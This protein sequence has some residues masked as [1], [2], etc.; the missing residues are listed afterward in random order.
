MKMQVPGPD[1]QACWKTAQ[2]DLQ[3]DGVLRWTSNEAWP[4]DAGAIDIKKALGVWLL[5]PPGWRRLD[6]ILPEHRWTL[7][8]DDDEVLQ[9][10]I[11][12][13]EDVAPEKPVSEIRNGWMEKKGAVGGGWKV[14]FFVLL[15]THELLYFESDRSPKCKGVID[16]KEATSCARVQTPDY[17]YEFAFEVVSPKRTWI[18]CPDDEHSMKEWMSDIQP[19]LGK[20]GQ[21]K[22]GAGGRKKRTSVSQ[23]GNRTYNTDGANGD[24]GGEG[25]SSEASSPSLKMGWLQKKGEVNT[26]W[27]NRYFVLKPENAYRDIPMT[28]WYYKDQ[29]TARIGK[30]GSTIEV[31][32]TS[33]TKIQRES[34]QEAGKPFAFAVVTPT[35]KYCLCASDED[36]LT[37]WIKLL[38]APPQEDDDLDKER[39]ESMMSMASFTASGPLVEVHSGWMKKKGQGM[40]GGKMQ[41]RYFVL[42]DNKELH[43]FEGQSMEN[44]Q[45]KGRIRMAEAVRVERQKPGDRKDF[46]FVIKEKTRDWILDPGSAGA[47]EEWF[48]KL[49]PMLKK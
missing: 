40:F 8:A 14:R 33:G 1:G 17:N 21:D 25:A 26:A 28:L 3:S 10:W 41:K 13:L 44:I 47:Y 20:A 38:S 16:L 45:R 42:Y 11:K 31:D 24:E 32:L 48:S 12:L 22:A 37:E 7:A 19:L 36:E 29:E 43:Y 2:F 9:K 4:W 35:R 15:S 5:G 6:I 39:S 18:L 49:S 34:E 27:K 23:H 30:N 46:T